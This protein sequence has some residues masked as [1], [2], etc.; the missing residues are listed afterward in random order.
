MS[1]FPHLL[2]TPPWVEPGSQIITFDSADY[3][4]FVLCFTI[5][6]FYLYYFSFVY[7]LIRSSDVCS[8]CSFLNF[9]LVS[10][11]PSV[12]YFLIYTLKL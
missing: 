10:V 8:F 6:Y 5:F 9:I 2:I 12:Y 3:L 4:L 1:L 7:F 11:F